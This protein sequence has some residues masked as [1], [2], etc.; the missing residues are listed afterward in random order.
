MFNDFLN[1]GRNDL[2]LNEQISLVESLIAAD[3]EPSQDE[4]DEILDLYMLEDK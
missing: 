4:D 2:S 3:Y 1:K